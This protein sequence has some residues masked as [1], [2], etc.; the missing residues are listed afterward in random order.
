MQKKLIIVDISSFIFRAFYAIRMLNAPDGTPV[1]AVRG[2]WSMLLKLISEHR[3]TH[4]FLARDSKGPTFRS[5]IFPEYKAHRPEPPEELIPQFALIEE[6]IKNMELHS[7]SLSEYEADDI[8]GSACVQWKDQFDEIIIASSD[9]DLMQFVGGNVRMLDTMKDLFY[10][11]QEVFDKMGVWPE[12]IVDYLSIVGDTSDNVPGMKG[13]GAK[14]A[15]KLLEEYETLEGCIQNKDKLKGK[16]VIEAFDIY[17]DNGL[18]S[19]KLI[20]IKTDLDL[21]GGSDHARFVFHPKEALKEFFIRL[22]FKSALDKLKEYEFNDHQAMMNDQNGEFKI[23]SQQSSKSFEAKIVEAQEDLKEI[24]ALIHKHKE[25]ACFSEYDKDDPIGSRMIGLG[26]SFDGEK[27]YYLPFEHGDESQLKNLTQDVAKKILTLLWQDQDKEIYFEHSKRDCIYCLGIGVDFNCQIFDI[28][29]AHYVTDP[30]SAHDFHELSSR[31]LDHTLSYCDK[32]EEFRFKASSF[33]STYMG[34]RAVGVY[35]LGQKFKTDLKLLKLESIYYDIDAPLIKVLAKMERE[36]VAIN[37]NYLKSLE[38]DLDSQLADIEAEI[39]ILA[40]KE[41]GV[42]ASGVNLKSPKQ[43]GHFLF[44]QMQLP[45]IKKTKTG[46]STDSEVL[47]ELDFRAVSEIPKYLLRYR[48]I[49]K[50]LSTYVRVLPELVNPISHRIHT[51]FSQHTAATG[52]LAS[53]NP[54]LQNIPIRSENGKKVRKAFIA[55]PGWLLLSA[56]YSQV[57]LRIL[58]HFSKDATMLKAFQ[59]DLDI[60]TQTA[61]EIMNVPPSKVT[62]NDRSLA[63]AVNFGLMYGQSSFGLANTLRIS[64]S[65]A[66]DYITKYFERF[67]SIKSY[68]DSLKEYCEVHG[69]TKTL[70]GRKRFLPDIHS[71]NR[72]IK[73]MA[74]RMAV[75]G[76]IQGT[77]ADIIKMAMLEIDKE[78][79][80]HQFR[81]RMLL[82]VHDELIFEV[83][84]DELDQVRSLVQNKMENTTK[85]T[86]PL[87]VDV[88]IGVNWFDLK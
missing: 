80:K 59:E 63:K 53:L 37:V 15:A 71:Q 78:M 46:A 19:K 28:T 34:E 27:S 49:D 44:E 77:A 9:K 45:I 22:G 38:K 56:D 79:Q 23:I 25:I 3:P 12:Q 86:V 54:N 82:Q 32:N 81:S 36:G 14:G 64:R 7:L 51:T 88:G 43:V 18:L 47:E 50:L 73:S 83:P 33:V 75:N 21:E 39:I 35:Q 20:Q 85:L 60:H 10:G 72:T 69:H 40:N 76:P 87:K 41:K 52:R 70:H 57:E 66:K 24:E 61:C 13:I 8:I 48:E 11:R 5:E 65:Q 30:G 29:Q 67:S 74:E 2:V 4:M 58:A 62:A 1:N 42:D 55:K 84:E 68:L 17:L 6:L 16:K 26:L 31:F